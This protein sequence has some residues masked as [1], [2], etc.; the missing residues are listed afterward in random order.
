MEIDYNKIDD[1]V[2]ALLHLT[3]FEVHDIVCSWKGHDWDALNRLFEK[4][5]ISNPKS[6]AKSVVLTDAGA[7][8]AHE[9]F[10]TYFR[11]DK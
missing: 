9:L 1:V 7:K 5:M 8:R 2:L 4:G 11:K 10:N 3:S 6:K